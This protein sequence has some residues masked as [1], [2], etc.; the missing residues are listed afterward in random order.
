[1]K[2][3]KN[4]AFALSGIVLLAV[5][6][7]WLLPGKVHVEK[8]IFINTHISLCFDQVN[9]LEN[10]KYWSP[11]NKLDSAMKINYEGKSGKGSSFSWQSSN[12]KVGS[13]TI[14][15]TECKPNEFISLEMD[16]EENGKASAY[17]RFETLQNKLKVFWGFDKDLGNNLFKRFFGRLIK[18]RISEYYDNGLL[19]LK[20]ISEKKEKES[21]GL[22]IYISPVPSGNFLA[23]AGK[24]TPAALRGKSAEYFTAIMDYLPAHKAQL[25]GA[26]I[27]IFHKLTKEIVT[28]EAALPFSGEIKNE[29]K[30][31]VLSLPVGNAVVADYYGSYQ[32]I[33]P[34]YEA[35]QKWLKLNSLKINGSPWE[36]YVTDP[37]MKKDTAQWLTKIYFPIL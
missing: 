8:T 24:C 1:M 18:R 35:I 14:T 9:I 31:K 6:I 23:L 10:W 4:A 21:R 13:G 37:S 17:F 25:T 7:A 19:E 16:M 30:F 5:F 22:R 33:G 3:L 34:A 11:W 2:K 27:L 20:T 28:F 26:P 32:K 29:G 15:I 12:S 36:E